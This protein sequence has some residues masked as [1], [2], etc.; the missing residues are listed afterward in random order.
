MTAVVVL[1]VKVPPVVAE[2]VRAAAANLDQS[3]SSLLREYVDAVAAGRRWQLVDESDELMGYALLLPDT[4]SSTPL[5][6]A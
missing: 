1:S 6:S 5:A 4:G 2:R 3:V